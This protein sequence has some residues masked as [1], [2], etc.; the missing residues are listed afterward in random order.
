MRGFLIQLTYW[1]PHT[2]YNMTKQIIIRGEE[3]EIERVLGLIEIIN[4]D[5]GSYPVLVKV[6]PDDI[7]EFIHRQ[8]VGWCEIDDWLAEKEN[9]NEKDNKPR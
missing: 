4:N 5:I 3:Y 1:Y 2:K 6:L 8:V 9:N 7:K